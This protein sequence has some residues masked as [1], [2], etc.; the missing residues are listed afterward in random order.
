MLAL[1]AKLGAAAS[2]TTLLFS[3]F[4]CNG[5]A[6]PGGIRN[7]TWVGLATDPTDQTPLG[8]VNDSGSLDYVNPTGGSSGTDESFSG[9]TDSANGIDDHPDAVT[10]SV[11]T[12]QMDWSLAEPDCNTVANL[13]L[14]PDAPVA[15]GGSIFEW[16]CLM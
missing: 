7:I 15:S 1:F 13:I 16:H 4:S 11:W 5:P 10:N 14:E 8:G 9:Y 2:A 3:L 12:L 6:F